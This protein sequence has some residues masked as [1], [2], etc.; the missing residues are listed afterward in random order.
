M[1]TQVPSILIPSQIDLGN[2]VVYIAETN[3]S[4]FTAAAAATSWRKL[5]VLKDGAALEH[6]LEKLEV[7]SGV[8]QRKVAT[9]FT[10]EDLK[11]SGQMGEFSATNLARTMGMNLTDITTTVKASSPAPTTVATGSTKTVI[12]VADAAGYAVDD[13]I[14]VGNASNNYQFGVI[15]S[16]SDD[17]IT[18][19]EGLSGDTNPTTGHAVAKVDTRSLIIGALASPNYKAIKVAK[20][21]VGGYGTINLYLPKVE[22]DGNW[23][24]NWQDGGGNVDSVGIPFMFDAVSDPDVESGALAQAIFTQS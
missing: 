14:R 24:I 18:L 22:A 10:K 2:P 23:T 9:F 15:K 4:S 8:P 6:I 1:T 12:N 5:G 3:F 16:I 21:L 17:A 7:Y 19:Y 20:T 11:L 13:E